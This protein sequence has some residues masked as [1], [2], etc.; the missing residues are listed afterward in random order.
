M[1]VRNFI[2]KWKKSIKTLYF[3]T[4]SLI[5]LVKESTYIPELGDY[6]GDF[7]SEL[8]TDEFISEFVSAGPKNNAYKT[9]KGKEVVKVKGFSFTLLQVNKLIIIIL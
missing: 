9:N 4:H 6:L 3:D 1:V 2:V 8:E 5:F 7:T